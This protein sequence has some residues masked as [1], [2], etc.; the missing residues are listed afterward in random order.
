M[1]MPSTWELE[2]DIEV[3]VI[4]GNEAK[5]LKMQDGQIVLVWNEQAIP[6]GKILRAL[7]ISDPW[8]YLFVYD[9]EGNEVGIIVDFN[10][11]DASSREIVREE[12]ERRYHIPKILRILQVERLP[13]TGHTRW[14]VETDEGIKEFVVPGSEHIY[15]ARYPRIFL[16]DEEGN[17]YEIPNFEKL[18]PKSRRISIQYL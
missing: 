17:R 1:K 14:K 16:V 9:I 10:E 5:F 8:R 2:P 4:K 3:R 18:D 15:T 6:V 13:Q 11:L 7:P 12:L